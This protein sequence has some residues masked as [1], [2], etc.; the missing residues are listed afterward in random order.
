MAAKESGASQP[1]LAGA[2]YSVA[3][4][5]A[6][7]AMSFLDRFIL[8]LLAAPVSKDLNLSDVQMSLL[9]GAGFAVVYALSGVP[10]AQLLDLKERRTIVCSGVATWSL[11]TIAAGF[12]N[13]FAM[14]AVCRAG[15]A[16]GEAVLAPAAISLI[17]DL[18]PR[19]KRALPIS[20]FASMTG[21]MSTGAFIIGAAALNLAT[22]I[23]PVT[24]LAPWRCTLLLVGAPG[25]LLAF[26][27]LTTI[28]E[29]A[30][31]GSV[32]EKDEVA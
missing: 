16:L 18:F 23:A 28:K 14:L 12:A 32:G 10:I 7:Y 8:S 13:S 1:R 11:S 15:V 6:L 30:R 26:V 29:P 27:F 21:L 9:L 19:E 5:T 17:A 3:L 24:G 20:V 2:W 4:L 22:A 31:V 25:L